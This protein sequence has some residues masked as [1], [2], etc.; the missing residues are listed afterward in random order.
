MPHLTGNEHYGSIRI[1]L[2]LGSGPNVWNRN[3]NSN[4]ISNFAAASSLCC[5]IAPVAL[6]G[7][8]VARGGPGI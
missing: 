4:Q 3:R 2:P 1:D 6:K 8:G 5:G 7:I